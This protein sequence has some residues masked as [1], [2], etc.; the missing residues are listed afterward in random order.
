MRGEAGHGGRRVAVIGLDCA[1]PRLLF[2]EFQTDM[3]QLA[4]HLDR[5]AWGRLRRRQ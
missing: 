3:P 1:T 2:D 5:S 4:A